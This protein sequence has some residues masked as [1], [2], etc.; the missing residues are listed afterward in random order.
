LVAHICTEFETEAED[1]FA[2]KILIG[3]V[4]KSK[5]AKAAIWNQLIGDNSAISEQIRTKFDTATE[6]EV[7]D[8]VSQAKLISQKITHGGSAILKFKLSVI[9]GP[10]LHI[11]A[12][13]SHTGWK[14]CPAARFAIKIHILQKS[15]MAAAAILKSVKRR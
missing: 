2:V 15:Q 11:F 8:Q 13:I 6:T 4:Q 5:I 12:Y 1:R 9:T 7:L 14:T 10:L 3:L